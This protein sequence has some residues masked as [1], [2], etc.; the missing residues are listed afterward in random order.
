MECSY[1]NKLEQ[2]WDTLYK[3]VCVERPA[4]YSYY[5]SLDINWGNQDNYQ[6]IHKLGRGKYSE[7]FEACNTKNNQKCVIKILKPVRTEKIYRE[8]KI[9]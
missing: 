1:K 2:S 7:V 8:I 9:L 6:L 5:Q 3:T 4:D